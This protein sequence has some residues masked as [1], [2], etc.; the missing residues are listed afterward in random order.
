MRAERSRL[1]KKLAALQ[2]GPL[3]APRQRANAS[4]VGPT[5]QDEANPAGPERP[6][7]LEPI[8]IPAKDD[9]ARMKV[10]I[11]LRIVKQAEQMVA[12]NVL[13]VAQVLKLGVD[14]VNANLPLLPEVCKDNVL[15]GSVGAVDERYLREDPEFRRLAEALLIRKME[16]E[17]AQQV[18]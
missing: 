11:G 8:A 1:R 3:P 4:A 12:R 10:Q 2:T 18:E 14:L 17:L 5:G 6:L 13:A 15:S 9:W 16:L 7:E